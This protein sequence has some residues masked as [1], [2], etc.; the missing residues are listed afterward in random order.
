MDPQILAQR[1]AIAK[2][3]FSKAIDPVLGLNSPANILSQHLVDEILQHLKPA[4][5]AAMNDQ[6][7]GL[8]STRSNLGTRCA[9]ISAAA[10]AT[11]VAVLYWWQFYH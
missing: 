10:A 1:C 2:I 9:Q 11:L 6:V 4:D 5:S 7:R 8:G 3:V